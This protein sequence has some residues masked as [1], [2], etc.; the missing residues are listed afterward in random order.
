MGASLEAIFDPDCN[1]LNSSDNKVAAIIK[2][3]P[4]LGEITIGDTF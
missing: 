3:L 1:T 4:N 2:K